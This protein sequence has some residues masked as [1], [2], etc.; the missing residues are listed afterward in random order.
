MSEHRLDRI[1]IERPRYG[2][3]ISSHK[4]IRKQ[5]KQELQQA[6]YDYLE[7][8]IGSLKPCYKQATR[9]I[10]TK[11]FSDHLNP[12]FRWLYSKKGSPWNEVYAELSQL[13]KFNTLSGQHILLHVWDFV[14]RDVVMI[15]NVPYTHK[16]SFYLRKYSLSQ[17]GEGFRDELYIHPETGILCVVKKQPKAKAK[18]PRVDYLWVD[19]YRQYYK[20][21]NIWYLVFFREVPKPFVAIV[22]QQSKIYPTKVRDVLE[23]RI[24]TYSELFTSNNVPLYAYYKRQCN[25]K[26]IKWLLQQLK[27]KSSQ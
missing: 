1:V 22:N 8:E 24:I 27:L 10:K 15:D 18:Q 9:G 16:Y 19:K 7:A 4:K 23:Q 25:K 13:L 5:I 3:R 2:M 6:K 11:S 17:L 14:E 20:L 26:E 12:L 21:D